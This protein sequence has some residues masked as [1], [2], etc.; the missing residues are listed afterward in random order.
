MCD[1]LVNTC[2][3]FSAATAMTHD[4]FEHVTTTTWEKI[5]NSYWL[6]SSKEK[7]YQQEK[8]AVSLSPCTVFYVLPANSK[9]PFVP[10]Q[11]KPEPLSP[12]E[13]Y[14][15]VTNNKLKSNVYLFTVTGVNPV[16]SQRTEL[17]RTFRWR[18]DPAICCLTLFMADWTHFSITNG[19][20]SHRVCSVTR[21]SISIN[22][23][24]GFDR[25][26]FDGASN[27]LLKHIAGFYSN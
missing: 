14:D 1:T 8:L 19:V 9:R 20:R 18:G 23:T 7:K 15:T 4:T 2:C 5:E 27:H 10:R 25:W 17:P 21:T 16:S 22:K 13:I 12:T 26:H 6:E 3:S 24:F 11:I